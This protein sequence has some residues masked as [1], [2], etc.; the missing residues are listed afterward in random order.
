MEDLFRYLNSFLLT[1]NIDANNTLREDYYSNFASRPRGYWTDN[2]DTK[3]RKKLLN[4]I[5]QDE[6][7]L[8]ENTISQYQVLKQATIDLLEGN[9]YLITIFNEEEKTRIKVVWEGEL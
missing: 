5:S 9:R 2:I 4:K 7:F 8:F 1:Q 6:G 3:T